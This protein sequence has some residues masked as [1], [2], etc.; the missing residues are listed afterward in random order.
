MFYMHM[1]AMV[2]MSGMIAVLMLTRKWAD[3]KRILMIIFSLCFLLLFSK[4]LVVF[5][6]AFTIINYFG[7]VYLCRTTL[8]RKATFI[9]G[10]AANIVGVFLG[11]RFFV[12][13]VFHNP[14]VRCHHLFRP[15]LQCSESD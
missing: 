15:H 6:A 13:G 11:V 9:F 14:V 7:F 2:A 4:K 1:N 10:I 3:N 5:Y 12:M 8:W